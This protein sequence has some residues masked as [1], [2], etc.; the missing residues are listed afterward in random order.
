MTN[1]EKFEE[2]FGF[3]P[4]VEFGVIDC[5]HETSKCPYYEKLDGGCHCESWWNETYKRSIDKEKT[6]ENT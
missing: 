2:V 3:K 6:D 4:D 5:P 1:A